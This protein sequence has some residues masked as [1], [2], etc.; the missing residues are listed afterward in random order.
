MSGNINTP[1]LQSNTG[2]FMAMRGYSQSHT[3]QDQKKVKKMQQ[4]ENVIKNK[5]KQVYY[6]MK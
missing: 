5:S 1:V 6:D 2:E 4:M 3:C